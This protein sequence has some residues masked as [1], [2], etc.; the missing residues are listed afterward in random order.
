MN[1]NHTKEII[2][3]AKTHIH[4]KAYR[5]SLLKAVFKGEGHSARI[6]SEGLRSKF[7]NNKQYSRLDDLVTDQ[8]FG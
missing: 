1:N 5:D 7:K 8:F 4:D 3:I 6:M 2:K